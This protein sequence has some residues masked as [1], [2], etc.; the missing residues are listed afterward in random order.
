MA[1]ARPGQNCGRAYSR[2]ISLTCM[3]KGANTPSTFPGCKR[4]T[5]T[6]ISSKSSETSAVLWPNILHLAV[7]PLRN[8]GGRVTWSVLYTC[9]IHYLLLCT[10]IWVSFRENEKWHIGIVS[11]KR[12]LV[13][14]HII[15]FVIKMPYV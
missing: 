4:R 12:D 5:S 13:H 15:K 10:H 6:K 3:C 2:P 8:G 14:V 7:S 11:A 1:S 9:I